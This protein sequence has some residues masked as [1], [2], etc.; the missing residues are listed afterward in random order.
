MIVNEYVEI[1]VIATNENPPV[2]QQTNPVS[3]PET[4]AISSS[5]VTVTATD[6]DFG[7][8]GQVRYFITGGSTGNAFAI[9]PVTGVISVAAAH[10]TF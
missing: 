6:D 2:F 5:V 4:A 1:T 7:V 10:P 8:N 3:I 9:D